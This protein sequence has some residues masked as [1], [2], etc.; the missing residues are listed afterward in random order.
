VILSASTFNSPKLLMLAGIG[1]GDHL[2][3]LGIEVRH[4]LPGVGRNLQDHPVS[5]I[6][7]LVNVRTNNQDANLMGKLRHGLRFALTRGG[8]AT[9]VQA[10]MAF[11]RSPRLA[12]VRKTK[13]RSRRHAGRCPKPSA[14]TTGERK[15]L[16]NPASSN[17]ASV[18]QVIKLFEKSRIGALI[19]P[20]TITP[21]RS[22]W[23]RAVPDRIGRAISHPVES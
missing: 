13:A 22:M 11:V 6:Q 3:D 17:P 5:N 12:P 9:Y 7:A 18:N 16:G 19:T 4:H 21:R 23:R 15:P 20:Q 10:A 2:Q 8:P 14:V 1:P